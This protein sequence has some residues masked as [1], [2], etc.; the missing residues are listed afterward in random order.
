MYEVHSLRDFPPGSCITWFSE[1]T[2]DQS[3]Q[4]AADFASRHQGRVELVCY[5]KQKAFKKSILVAYKRLDILD[6]YS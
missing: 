6:D 3:I 2:Y 5:F 4:A 1:K